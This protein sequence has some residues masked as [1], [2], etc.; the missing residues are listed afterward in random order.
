VD[1]TNHPRSWLVS[2]HWNQPSLKLTILQTIMVIADKVRIFLTTK[3]SVLGYPH[4]RPAK[5]L[6][7]HAYRFST[8]PQTAISTCMS[9][10][11]TGIHYCKRSTETTSLTPNDEPDKEGHA[12][13]NTVLSGADIWVY[14]MKNI[15]IM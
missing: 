8:A 11:A 13:V 4:R 14:I 5:R 9:S 1:N 12:V 3:R 15:K 2:N 6:G 7:R 10:F